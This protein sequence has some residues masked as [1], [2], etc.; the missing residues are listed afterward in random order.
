M[1]FKRLYFNIIIRV[2]LLA[3]TALGLAWAIITTSYFFTIALLSILI[4]IQVILLIKYLNKTNRLLLR[5]FTA[6]RDKSTDQEIIVETDD[7]NLDGI[8]LLVNE[9]NNSIQNT[10]IEKEA[11]YNYLQTILEQT[12]TG[13]VVIDNKGKVL[14]VNKAALEIM[15][16]SSLFKISDLNTLRENFG[17]D[18]LK[19]RAGDQILFKI[20]KDHDILHLSVTCTEIRV[21]DDFNKIFSIQNIKREIEESEIESWRKLIRVLNHEIRNSI[22]PITSISKALLKVLTNDSGN[23]KPVNALQQDTIDDSIDGLS[24]I[25]KRG[26]NLLKFVSSFKDYTQL[27]KPVISEVTAISL[28]HD[29]LDLLKNEIE[30][31][32]INLNLKIESDDIILSI[33][34]KMI[35]QVFINIIR[36]AIESLKESKRTKEIEVHAFQSENKIQILIKDNGPGISKDVLEK[37]FIPFYTTKKGGSGIGLSLSRQI[38]QLH[39]GSISVQSELGVE[40]VFTLSF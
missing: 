21:Q 39:G 26:D 24:T 34:K 38:M 10:R 23:S 31:N 36:N 9:I 40:T 29:N 25:E 7:R 20:S 8:I 16:I 30:T 17:D 32:K 12:G 6:L 3:A 18:I 1:I 14:L 5:F 33:D 4:A 11:H 22:S 27:P 19:L 13:L 37:I 2:L 28:I 15:G 35:D